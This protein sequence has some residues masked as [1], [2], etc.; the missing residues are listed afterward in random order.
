MIKPIRG[1]SGAGMFSPLCSPPDKNGAVRSLTAPAVPGPGVCIPRRLSNLDL[2]GKLVKR[3]LRVSYH[4]LRYDV[5][6]V[7]SGRMV[8][9]RAS[10]GSV[11]GLYAP[12]EWLKCESVQVVA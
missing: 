8:G 4:G 6:R 11:F 7:R 5:V 2:N 10:L 12:D 3:G 9:R 1:Q